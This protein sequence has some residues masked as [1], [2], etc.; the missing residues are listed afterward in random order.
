MALPALKRSSQ[1]RRFA[2]ELTLLTLALVLLAAATVLL[3]GAYHRA[4]AAA[5]DSMESRGVSQLRK[6]DLGASEDSLRNALALNRQNFTYQF[7][8]A[9]ALAAEHRD[10]EAKDYLL[11]LWP[12]DPGDGPLNT[13]LA[14]IWRRE[15]DATMTAHYYEDAIYG[16]WPDD[17][18]SQRTDLR[19]EFADYLLSLK[20]A[21]AADAE[22]ISASQALP[23]N[24]SVYMH[25]AQLFH[26]AGDE[27]RALDAYRTAHRLAPR[28]FASL[29]GEAESAFNLGLYSESEVLLRTLPP[30]SAD[31]ETASGL[32]GAISQIRELSPYSYRISDKDRGARVLAAVASATN[33]LAVCGQ[34][35]GKVPDA[36]SKQFASLQSEA[37][38]FHQLV[39]P[40]TLAQSPDLIDTAM[41][42][43]FNAEEFTATQCG[44]PKGADFA[45]LTLGRQRRLAQ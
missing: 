12:R 27:H 26:R 34:E 9:Q 15:G 10:E 38:G 11:N 5:A 22:L 3:S 31:A 4:R 14:R 44:A 13:E 39:T 43:V 37:A 40:A 35:R 33:R 36:V 23:R 42:F 29:K 1:L 7:R 18:E 19:L 32:L 28:D 21:P 8:Y 24:A 25:L 20:R 16:A 41:T 6:G 30:H 17:A 45:L 2:A